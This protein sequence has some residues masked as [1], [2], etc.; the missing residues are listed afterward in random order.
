M[1]ADA[2][3]AESEVEKQ[4]LGLIDHVQFLLAD[5]LAIDEARCKAGERRLVPGG[6]TH[7]FGEFTDLFL[8]QL[9]ITKRALDAEF[10]DRDQSRAVIAVIVHIRAFRDIFDAVFRGSADDLREELALTDIASVFRVLAESVDVE[11]LGLDHDL[12]DAL[13]LTE[14]G[15]L[16]E[17]SS[18]KRTRLRGHG[19]RFVAE[20]V[21]GNFQ[22]EGRVH[23]GRKSDRE[24]SELPK[25][26]LKFLFF[27][28]YWIHSFLSYP[29][30]SFFCRNNYIMPL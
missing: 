27:L 28:M 1:D 30:I 11:F 29:A 4:L 21:F 19:D 22:K 26:V 14:C 13:L 2:H 23:A 24:T 6:K 20:D 18:R 3:L 10:R 17:L 12:A 7:L 8:R 9:R 16:V 15:R 25:V 5:R